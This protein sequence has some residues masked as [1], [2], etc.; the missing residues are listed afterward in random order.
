MIKFLHAADLHLD[1][2]FS[3]L[4]PEKAAARRG[5][6]RALL[7]ALVELCND[8][9][10][11]LLLLAGDLFDA[12][13][14][15]RESVE[16]LAR[17]LRACRARVFIAPGNH[18]FD[19]PGSPYR[20]VWPEGVHIF[21]KQS[22]EP[23]VLEDLNAVVWGAAFTAPS[24]PPLLEGF[25]AA[26]PGRLNLMVL[27]GDAENAASSYNPVS[28]DQIAASGLD[29]LA[30]GHAHAASGPR[31]AGKTVYAWPGCAM[32]RG[33]DELGE[34][35]VYLGT[36]SESACELTF[37][38][39]PGRRY[40]LLRVEA[41]DDP[42]AAILAALP[43]RTEDDSY[44]ICLTGPAEPPDLRALA[45]ALAPR[46]FSL[47]LRDETRPRRD[48]WAEAGDDTLA[49]LFLK[50]LQEKRAGDPALYDLAASL[51]VAALEG[52]EALTG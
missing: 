8:E 21:H 24:A 13:S 19:A 38:P 48:L 1:S 2:P 50:K 18:D 20:G 52:R 44:R 26:E 36:L 49:G 32:G 4:P 42:L 35:G 25:H 40:E 11:D 7:D 45:E 39:L 23:V 3:G 10:C 15:R 5:E 12:A 14:A 37:R 22:P 31:R 27:H 30:L 46:F 34:K 43:P 9:R 47:S 51:G 6:Q 16:A 29:Y 17:S 28:R 33:Y 41:G